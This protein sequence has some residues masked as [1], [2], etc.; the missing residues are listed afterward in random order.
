MARIPL[1]DGEQDDIVRALTLSPNFAKAMGA[2]S[3]AIYGKISLSMREREAA[4]MRIAQINQCTICLGTRFPELQAEGINEDFYATIENWR[5]SDE[6]SVREKLA[7]EYA[8]KFAT[9][10][11]NLDNDFFQ[12]LQEHFSAAEVFELSCIIAGLLANGRLLQVLQLD[13]QCKL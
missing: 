5:N 3:D 10:H 6:F 13:Q 4:R 8:D 1:P 9:N 12:Q 7:I 11:L 2:Y